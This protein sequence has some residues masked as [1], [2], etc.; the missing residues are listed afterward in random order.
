M[1]Y[2]S[3]SPSLILQPKLLLLDFF[4]AL[5]VKLHLA[6]TKNGQKMDKSEHFRAILRFKNLPVRDFVFSGTFD[7]LLAKKK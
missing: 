2:T 1:V 7:A 3:R 5:G 6:V 4:P